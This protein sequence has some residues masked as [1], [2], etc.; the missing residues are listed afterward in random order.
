M[1]NACSVMLLKD[2]WNLAVDGLQHRKTTSGSTLVCMKH[3]FSDELF[4][5]SIFY[6]CCFFCKLHQYMVSLKKK[7]TASLS[8]YTEEV[9][10]LFFPPNIMEVISTDHFT[11]DKIC[12]NLSR[13]VR[14]QSTKNVLTWQIQMGLKSQ[15]W[16]HYPA[17]PFK[18]NRVQI[19]LK[20][21][22]NRDTW[23]KT[24]R[25]F[26]KV[27][28]GRIYCGGKTFWNMI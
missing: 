27:K 7:N 25:R 19:D 10:K 26:Q 23:H 14:A 21:R 4:L 18:M 24:N 9:R 1:P 17:T 16:L 20:T 28:F 15:R 13:C 22:P 5:I 3:H 11:E 2:F 8:P 12:H 6:Y